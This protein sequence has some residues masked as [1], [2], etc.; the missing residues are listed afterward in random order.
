MSQ[1]KFVKLG[2]RTG[3]IAVALAAA[4][5][6][7]IVIDALAAEPPPPPRQ[8]WEM[9]RP[10][11]EMIH[12]P[13]PETQWQRHDLTVAETLNAL[14]LRYQATPAPVWVFYLRQ[15]NAHDW[16]AL[17][18]DA[19]G[20]V[21]LAQRQSLTTLTAAAGQ[22]RCH[23]FA[24]ELIVDVDGHLVFQLNDRANWEIFTVL[25]APGSRPPVEPVY[26]VDFEDGFMRTEFARN[27]R[28]RI[29]SGQWQLKQYGGGMPE[30][31]AQAQDAAFR[32][33]SNPFTMESSGSGEVAYG[34]S[35]WI[36]VHLGVNFFFGRPDSF[37]ARDT[38]RETRS[39]GE[40]V[41]G[42]RSAIFSS[43]QIQE[44]PE[45]DF[46]IAQG[47]PGRHR[48]SFGWSQQAQAFQ[49]RRQDPNQP[50][51]QVLRQ[52]QQR[53]HFTN[54]VR[55]GLGVIRGHI[56]APFLDGEQLGAFPQDCVISGPLY[57]LSAGGKA[58]FD[59]VSA[60]SYPRQRRL[61]S[62]VFE[63][64]TIFA[65]KELLPN[66]DQQTGQWTRSELTFADDELRFRG[67]TWNL[68]RCQVPI[69]GEFTY[70]ADPE[71]APGRYLLALVTAEDRPLYTGIF[72]KH[73]D[74]WEIPGQGRVPHL[75]LQRRRDQILQRSGGQ[76][77]VLSRSR[78]AGTVYFVVGVPEGQLLYPHQHQ[79]FS[80]GL[81]QDL[82]E[83]APSAWAWREGNF[84]MDVRWE[85]QRGWNFMMGKSRDLAAMYS[86]L[87]FYG[88]HEVEFYNSLRFV[89]PSRPHG[90]Y[91]L[92]DLGFAFC[93]DGRSLSSGYTLIYGDN[94][95]RHITLLRQGRIVAQVDGR[96]AP[97]HTNN[98]HNYWWHCR[99]RRIGATITIEIDGKKVIEYRDPQPLA[100]GHIAFW[101]FRNSFSLAK[102]AVNAERG[103]PRS[104]I[105]RVPVSMD[106]DQNSIWQRL[107]RDEVQVQRDRSG[108]WRVTNLIGGGTF[109]VRH[110]YGENAPALRRYR[111]LVLPLRAD[112]NARI[113]IHLQIS[114]RSFYYAY[115]APRQRLRY[116]LT[117]AFEQADPNLV[118]RQSFFTADELR[119]MELPGRHTSSQVV[120]DLDQLVR[121]NP[122]ARLE[123]ITIG[124][125][126]NADY[127]MLGAGGN[128]VDCW[129]ALG[130]AHLR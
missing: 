89:T 93:T 118:Y 119:A 109:A 14:L 28:W 116:L 2:S 41:Y 57:L 61:G 6:F 95:N 105:F 99:V 73:R 36:N 130:Q 25:T 94:D 12:L 98:I 9:S 75:E 74:G 47:E 76:R 87:A 19:Q 30:T 33:A 63:Q 7:A 26:A 80:Q 24:N 21:L 88:D 52:W 70:R 43:D 5:M 3:L 59:D 37:L 78:V 42:D 82:F 22:V 32:R 85:C 17:G 31:E 23:V 44:Y 56:L 86:K 65:Q 29:D 8:S 84:R 68:L 4:S 120:I 83:Q 108:A 54:W 129:Y 16:F 107:N 101:T 53:P 27:D 117:P 77:S 34:Q 51:W 110:D 92:R 124:N 55:L 62:P 1:R 72:D 126:S 127:L 113:G 60:W 58:E 13:Q 81:E 49:L 45:A 91:V 103:V 11:F 125:S 39:G 67:I 115:T 114:G 35:H 122:D 64:S 123:S 128:P 121:Q 20:Q 18:T 40:P 111:Q 97:Q 15:R 10:H 50:H 96:I 106:Q 46:F 38:L 90:Y 69:Y 79:L 112:A 104:E 66:R 48:V 100:G 102:V 71:L